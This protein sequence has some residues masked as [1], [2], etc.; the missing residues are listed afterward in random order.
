MKTETEGSAKIPNGKD[1]K[2][3][4][5]NGR[6]KGDLK[7]RTKQFALNIVALYSQLPKKREAQVLGDQLLRSG[8]SVGAHFREAQRAKSSPDFISKIEGG[9]QELEETA[10]WLELLDGARLCGRDQLHRKRFSEHPGQTPLNAYLPRYS[11]IARASLLSNVPTLSILKWVWPMRKQ[12]ISSGSESVSRL[13][14][15]WLDLEQLAKVEVTSE[16]AEHP[17]EFALIPDRGLGWRAAQPGK[18]TIRLIFDHPLSLG[19]ILLRFDENKAK[20]TQEFVLRWLPEGH[21]SPREIVRQ[22]YIFSPPATNQESEDYRVN[23]NGVTALELEIVPD[24]SGGD[25]SASLAQM[26]LA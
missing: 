11:D 9:M 13:D 24:I 1:E 4:G 12:T 17:I 10:Y 3:R 2:M 18:Q 6:I 16:S 26:R 21:Q 7:E 5:E 8:T 19:R 22:Q 25:A 20:R 15:A 14:D 23:L